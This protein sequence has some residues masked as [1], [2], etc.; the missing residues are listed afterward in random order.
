MLDGLNDLLI[1]IVAGLVWPVHAFVNEG[2]SRYFWLYCFTG[3]VLGFYAHARLNSRRGFA[4]TLFDRE[5]WT[6]RS[7][8]ND[9][10]VLVLGAVLRFTLLSWAF[11]N[12][13][14]IAAF[15]AETLGWLGVA[16][17]VT[18]PAAVAAGI[19]L[20]VSLFL[21]DDFLKFYAHL[22]MH[23]IPELWEFHKVHHSAEH[24]N[25]ATAER[26]H[27]L[28]VVFT[29]LIGVLGIGVVNGVF[30]ALCGQHLTP[31]TVC[32]AN[33]LLFA[34]NIAGGVLRHSPCW[35]SFGP[36]VERWLISPA[37]HQIHHSEDARHFDKNM[38]AALSVWDRMF[39]TLYIPKGADEIRT[40]GIGAETAEFRSLRA[41]FLRPFAASW[42]L[43]TD[44]VGRRVAKP[45]QPAE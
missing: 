10:W 24:L 11:F 21:V 9:Y 44:R 41:I 42:Q 30:I 34:T 26:L 31:L 12:W 17:T 20:T 39:G 23:R 29:S 16:G 27:P 7:A 45:M 4:E 8:W 5:V 22:L 35:V 13:Q 15:V 14:P 28:E 6:S 37:M 3:V 2:Q 43:L 32:G 36:A 1:R 19:A 33:A 18:G 25:F 40:Y 38:G